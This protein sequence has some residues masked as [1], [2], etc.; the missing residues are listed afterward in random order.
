MSTKQNSATSALIEAKKFLL[1]L[2]GK[3][4]FQSEMKQIDQQRPFLFLIN[5]I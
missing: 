4:K 5:H 1:V 3:R 2:A